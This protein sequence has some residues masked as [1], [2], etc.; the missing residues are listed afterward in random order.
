M[1]NKNNNYYGGK[2][3]KNGSGKIWG[4]LIAFTLT[5]AIVASVL[6]VGTGGFKDWSFSKWFGG[7][8]EQNQEQASGGA[9]ITDTVATGGISLMSNALS[10]ELF[11]E[12][13]VSAAAETAYTITATAQPA[14]ALPEIDW[15]IGFQ[16]AASTWA[17]GKSVS[18]YVTYTVSEDTTQATVSCSKAFGEPIIITATSAYNTEAKATCK[19]DYVRAIQSIQTEAAIATWDKD[20]RDFYTFSVNINVTYGIGTLEGTLATGHSN[21]TDMFDFELTE[22]FR[23]NIYSNRYYNTAFDMLDARGME[24]NLDGSIFVAMDRLDGGFTPSN[25]DLIGEQTNNADGTLSIRYGGS[26]WSF[27]YTDFLRYNTYYDEILGN[28]TPTYNDYASS[29]GRTYFEYALRYAAER[30]AQHFSFGGTFDYKY[31]SSTISSHNVSGNVNINVSSLPT[32]PTT[33]NV[34][35][36]NGNIIFLP[37]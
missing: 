27:N 15:S 35:I 25:A 23:S 34:T 22:A 7:K 37:N 5:A 12:N 4:G 31:G 16:N 30:T 21:D 1:A 32:I 36:N 18:D 29:S 28:V 6:G 11:A 13:G 33:A 2:R 8:T 24:F 14:A 9:V 20:S 10:P 19:V 3:R 26:D 17:N